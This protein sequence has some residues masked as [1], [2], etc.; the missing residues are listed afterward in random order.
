MIDEATSVAY[1]SPWLPT[2]D[3]RHGVAGRVVV[4]EDWRE[5]N[6]DGWH[7]GGNR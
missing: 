3:P 7:R 5:E 6:N 2:V 4:R 1:P